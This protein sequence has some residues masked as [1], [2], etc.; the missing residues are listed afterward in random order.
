MRAGQAGLVEAAELPPPRWDEETAFSHSWCTCPY[1]CVSGCTGENPHSQPLISD[2]GGGPELA[3]YALGRTTGWRPRA[4]LPLASVF[5]CVVKRRRELHPGPRTP[6]SGLPRGRGAYSKLVA[7]P[8]KGL[9]HFA[10]GLTR[11][12]ADEPA[13]VGFGRGSADTDLLHYCASSGVTAPKVGCPAR[14]TTRIQDG[15]IG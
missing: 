10:E 6:T 13:P 7:P 14:Q 11:L 8:Q 1:A 4:A 15:R 12:V 3:A 9:A 2:Q 5:V